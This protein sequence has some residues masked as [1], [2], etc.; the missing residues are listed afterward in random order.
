MSSGSMKGCLTIIFY[1]FVAFLLLASTV[2]ALGLFGIS[3]AI[4]GAVFTHYSPKF[5][6][7]LYRQPGF[8]H[9]LYKLPGLGSRGPT[10]MVVA[11]LLYLIP[12]SFL[13]WYLLL[14]TFSDLG[15]TIIIAITGLV[16]M[17]ILYGWF[18]SGWRLP[19]GKR[20]SIQK[21]HPSEEDFLLNILQSVRGNMQAVSLLVISLFSPFLCGGIGMLTSSLITTD[22]QVIAVAT[23]PTSIPPTTTPLPTEAIS[24]IATETPLHLPSATETQLMELYETAQVISVIDGDTIEVSIGGEIWKVRYIGIDS[25]EIG[26][27]YG[28]ECAEANRNL[29][30]GKT[31][32]L[33]KDISETDDYGRLLRY[34]YLEDNTFVNAELILLGFAIVKSYPPD[35]KYQVM[36]QRMQEKAESDSLG[37]WVQPEPTETLAVASPGQ[38]KIDGNCSQFDAP[39]DDNNNKE[40]EYVCLKNIG[41]QAVDMRNWR[42]KDEHGWTY[43]FPAFTL[44]LGGR[45]RIRTGC[46]S[47]TQ[48]DLY[49]CKSG[50]A[51]WNNDGDTA[52]LYDAGGNLIDS[53]SY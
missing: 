30:A 21:T 53:F 22:E 4:I 40:E 46:G 31:V 10:T 51:V 13:C 52:F 26:Q 36:F 49:W 19:V 47:N 44:A 17:I 11:I 15:T 37:L 38:V 1:I 25:P 16:G 14:E 45:V 27:E 39:G 42:I 48:E 43:T 23:T 12:L 41:G 34:V 5:R 33:E 2:S 18:I 9:R 20:E 6:R 29:V 28:N 35:V 3:I 32:L 8:I 24:P 50:S 7:W